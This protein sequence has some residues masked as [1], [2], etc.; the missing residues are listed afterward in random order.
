MKYLATSIL[1]LLNNE[2]LSLLTLIVLVVLFMADL[3]KARL[4]K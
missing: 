1:F 2:I 3:M 4:N